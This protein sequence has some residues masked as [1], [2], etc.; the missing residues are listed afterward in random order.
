L[1]GVNFIFVNPKKIRQEK[2]KVYTSICCALTLP[3]NSRNCVLCRPQSFVRRKMFDDKICSI[4]VAV[5]K[6]HIFV[7]YDPEPERGRVINGRRWYEASGTKYII[8]KA[9][10]RDHLGAIKDGLVNGP[11]DYIQRNYDNPTT[12]Q[13][14]KARA[15][16]LI[17]MTMPSIE[18]VARAQGVGPV[19]IL[20]RLGVPA[21]SLIWNLYRDTL[22]HNDSWMRA[23]VDG[24]W[25]SP[26]LLV[27]LGPSSADLN[28]HLVNHHTSTHT[29][30]IG[31][32]CYDLIEYLKKEI[33]TAVDK[34]IEVISG[35][36]YLGDSKKSAVTQIIAEITYTEAERKYWFDRLNRRWSAKLRAR[37][38]LPPERS[39]DSK[40][41]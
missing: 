22:S 10:Y 27:S 36:E 34:E 18:T 25:I 14:E 23:K 4:G 26:Q 35:I 41:D 16:S 21:P 13:G 19:T 29:L 33:E 15:F 2:S 38:L 40:E 3:L 9:N 32:L 37:G 6:S 8:K 11:A 17:R 24:K 30:D 1:R 28:M 12:Q 7:A 20:G 31:E 5:S 39:V